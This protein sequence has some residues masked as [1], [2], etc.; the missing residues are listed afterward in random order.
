MDAEIMGTLVQGQQWLP[1]PK[2][3]EE[4]KGRANRA[5]ARAM[6]N[7]VVLAPEVAHV[8]YQPLYASRHPRKNNAT[9]MAPARP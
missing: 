2:V 4:T 3:V 6:R 8:A 7:R 9:R 1:C 5:P